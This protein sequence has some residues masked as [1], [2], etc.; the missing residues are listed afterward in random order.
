MIKKIQINQLKVGMFVHDFKC[1]WLEHPFFSNSKKVSS[2]KILEKI[3]HHGIHELYIDT[4][5]GLD[6]LN[7]PTQKE[8]DQQIEKEIKKVSKGHIKKTV[9]V[10]FKEEIV[11]AKRIR[12]ESKQTVQNIMH[13]V[14]L[15][16]QVKAEQA[17]FTVEK[18]IDSIYRNPHALLSLTKIRKKDE[19]TYMHSVSVSA[20]LIS[21]GKHL[22]YNAGTLKELG[23]GGL[24][25]DIGKMKVPQEILNKKGSLT[26]KEYEAMK[27]HVEY[28]SAL[29]EEI[30]GISN[31]AGLV[32]SQHHER[33]D[34]TGYPLGLKGDEISEFGQLA[35]IVD[36]YDAMTANRCYRG[37]QQPAEVM[38]NLYE[39]KEHHFNGKLVEE[40]VRCVGIYP[41]GSLVRLASGLLAVVL[42]HDDK[43]LLNPAVKVV[44]NTKTDT[45]V[46]PYDLDLSTKNDELIVGHELPDNWNIKPENYI[47]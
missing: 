25:H 42:N 47:D 43:D 18:M 39:W 12:S 32:A 11:I 19:Y 36:V 15:G 10:A 2:T 8:V 23:L 17:E 24:L 20:L 9:R 41:T 6:V 21:F 38:K 26:N 7:A 40:F 29:L 37:R 1:G 14:K 22:G 3:I 35:A 44:Y 27:K 5:K 45:L 31:E 13:D 28:S 30:E 4:N 16:N 46:Y 33:I 34:G